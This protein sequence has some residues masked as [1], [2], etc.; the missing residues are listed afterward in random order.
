MTAWDSGGFSSRPP[1]LPIP[2][3]AV[4]DTK[5]FVATNPSAVSMEDE[6]KGPRQAGCSAELRV[7]WLAVKLS[8]STFLFL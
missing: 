3:V 8:F 2:S 5:D 4:A 6:G 7:W 1:L